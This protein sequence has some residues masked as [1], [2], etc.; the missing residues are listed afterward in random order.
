MLEIG[1][2][3]PISEKENAISV[4]YLS[5]QKLYHCYIVFGNAQRQT[6]ERYGTVISLSYIWI[7]H[8]CRKL[9]HSDISCR[10]LA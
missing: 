6:A 9:Y 5:W 1:Y 8:F 2:I 7:Y 10:I 3:V 4:L